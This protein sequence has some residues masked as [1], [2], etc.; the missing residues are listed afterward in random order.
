MV[1]TPRDSQGTAAVGLYAGTLGT[2]VCCDH[3]DPDLPLY[4]SW[5]GWANGKNSDTYCDPPVMSYAPNSGWWVSCE[6]IEPWN[7]GDTSGCEAD[8]TPYLNAVWTFTPR[9]LDLCTSGQAISITYGVQNQGCDASGSYSVDFY[10]STDSTITGS[11]Y[12]LG[13]IAKNSFAA[14]ERGTWRIGGFQLDPG[15]LPSGTYYV[16]FIVDGRNEVQE[17]LETNNV[18]LMPGTLTVASCGDSGSTK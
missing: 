9:T 10:A 16:A 5:D 3:D 11:D 13:K 8:L 6:L 17:S 12:L 15:Q 1:D 4:V 14:G 18:G 2:V 7:D